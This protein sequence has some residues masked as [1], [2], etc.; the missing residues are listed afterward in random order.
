MEVLRLSEAASVNPDCDVWAGCQRLPWSLWVM[1][2][3]PCKWWLKQQVQRSEKLC[4][5]ADCT[6]LGLA[7]GGWHSLGEVSRGVVDLHLE[8]LQDLAG[9]SQ[10]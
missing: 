1:Y 6:G 3:D 7:L 4:L 2:G 9:Q 5:V 8:A 10:A